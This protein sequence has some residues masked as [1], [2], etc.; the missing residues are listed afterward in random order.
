MNNLYDGQEW[1]LFSGEEGKGGGVRRKGR[2]VQ[3]GGREETHYFLF[4]SDEKN[5]ISKYK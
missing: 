1:K 5:K 2:E 3:R 4:S